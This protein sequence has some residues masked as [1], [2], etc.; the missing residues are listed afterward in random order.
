MKLALLSYGAVSSDAVNGLNVG[1]NPA[2]EIFVAQGNHGRLAVYSK[3]PVESILSAKLKAFL[4]QAD[5]VV[6]YLGLGESKLD[7]CLHFL[8]KQQIAPE[9]VI[10]VLCDCDLSEKIAKIK[11]FGYEQSEKIVTVFCGGSVDMQRFFWNAV[12]RGIVSSVRLI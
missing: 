5:K 12:D 8:S 2:D 6:V 1:L 7:S 10:F 3:D 4:L 9:K 11:S